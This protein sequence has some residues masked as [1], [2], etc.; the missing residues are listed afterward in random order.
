VEDQ[1]SQTD[2]GLKIFRSHT[3][4]SLLLLSPSQAA[5]MLGVGIKSITKWCASGMISHHRLPVTG[6][7]AGHIRIS[8]EEVVKF[9]KD[10]KIPIQGFFNRYFVFGCSDTIVSGCPSDGR[11]VTQAK[12]PFE[13]GRVIDDRFTANVLIG[14]GWS[15]ADRVE[16]ACTLSRCGHRVIVCDSIV[17]D[18]TIKGEVP[19]EVV[20]IP[21]RQWTPAIV[22]SAVDRKHIK[23]RDLVEV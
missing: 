11:A 9:A 2:S 12:S 20:V 4:G 19:V 1:R 22:W 10:H 15:Q 6:T 16:A 18:E 3:G 23:K 7:K 17:A 21:Y 8:Q 14:P 13:A 5:T